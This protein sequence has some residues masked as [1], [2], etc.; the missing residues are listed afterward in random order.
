M[1]DK[2]APVVPDIGTEKA[3]RLATEM[4]GD[5]GH[6]LPLDCGHSR[7]AQHPVDPGVLLDCPLCPPSVGG[8]LAR[9]RVLPP[10]PERRLRTRLA[11]DPLAAT[12]A[13]Q[14]AAETVAVAGL[15]ALVDDAEQLVGELVANAASRTE[16]PLELTVD[17]RDQV[18]RVEV[19]EAAE[20]RSAGR[21]AEGRRVV[22]AELRGGAAG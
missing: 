7:H 8:G 15:D 21:L 12:L 19:R 11:A 3:A 16:A 18:V 20:R 14:L 1:A 13:R 10:P 9:R 5:P 22:W 2:L 6:W 17:A 4:T